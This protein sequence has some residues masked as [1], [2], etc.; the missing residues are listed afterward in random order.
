[1]LSNLLKAAQIEKSGF[2]ST[3]LDFQTTAPSYELC[4]V[5]LSANS[6]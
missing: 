4:W 2:K 5:I 1:M 3:S 6:H